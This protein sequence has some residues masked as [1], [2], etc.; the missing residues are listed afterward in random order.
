MPIPLSVGESG[1][2]VLGNGGEGSFDD[3]EAFV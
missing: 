3:V 1:L 2:F